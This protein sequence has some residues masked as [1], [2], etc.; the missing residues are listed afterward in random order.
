MKRLIAAAVVVVCL[1]VLCTVG[2]MSVEAA[3]KQ[4]EKDI[5]NCV[6]HIKSDDFKSAMGDS[7]TIE[8]EWEGKRGIMSVFINHQT[9][10]EIDSSVTQ[11]SSFANKDNKAH[12]LA[13]CELI[14]LYL[15][16]MREYCS[17]SLHTLF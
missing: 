15:T 8:R 1:I 11:L 3:C 4:M 10:E 7:Q 14:K 2:I 12:F 17:V 6:S 5:N 13:E 9:I 16:E